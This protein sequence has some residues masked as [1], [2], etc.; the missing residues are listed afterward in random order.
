MGAT[1]IVVDRKKGRDF[2]G[3]V[4]GRGKH[5]VRADLKSQ[6]GRDMVLRLSEK[7]D[8]LIEGFRPGVM[9]RLGL[10][11]EELLACNPR[12]VY[13]RMTGWGQDGP[14]AATAGHDITYLAIT[15]ALH[16]MGEP[17]RPPV[18]PLNL[19]A[20]YGGGSMMLLAGVL[21]A[22][23]ERGA[24][25][26]GQVVDAAMVDGVPAMMALVHSMLATGLWSAR[27]GDNLLDGAAPFY[28]CYET[29][30]GK[31][32]AVGALE[33]QFFAILAEKTGL[34]PAWRQAQMDKAGWPEMAGE[35]ARIFLTRSRDEWASIFEASDG[36]VAPVLDFAE[37]A[38]HPHNVSRGVFFEE[39]GVVQAAPA[40]RFSRSTRELPRSSGSPVANFEA[41]LSRLGYASAEIAQLRDEG[42]IT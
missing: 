39:D 20:D 25:G 32:V 17:G 30:D 40:P 13:G 34:D 41:V 5:F 24:S 31:Y 18:P 12:L 42:A 9:E 23:V 15:G 33:P 16:A 26:K 8:V 7:A 2:T 38:A 3:L 19:V 10:G 36:C 6:A 29:A 28:R 35:L 27:R 22:L 11:P 37:A 1:V 14:L 4:N 21:A